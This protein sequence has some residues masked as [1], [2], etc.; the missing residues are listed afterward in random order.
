[1]TIRHFR[2]FLMVVKY[3]SI[4][5]AAQHLYLSQPAVSL[6]IKE[7]ESYYGIQLFDRLSR[8][9][10]ITDEGRIIY[11]TALQIIKNLDDL[12]EEIKSGQFAS[13]LRLGVSMTIGTCYLPEILRLY[14]RDN[15]QTDIRCSIYNSSILAQMILD[16]QIDLAII[17]GPMISE[18]MTI[19][20]IR[21]D[22]LVLIMSKKHCLAQNEKITLADLKDQE[23]LLRDHD[24]GT[25]MIIDSIFLANGLI[26]E[27]LIESASTLALIEAVRCNLGISIIPRQFMSVISRDDII[28][29]AIFDLPL[30]RSLSLIH[31]RNKHFNASAE[32]FIQ[33]AENTIRKK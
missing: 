23:F 6:A 24:S 2:I 28:E 14:K 8:R 7:M 33:L 5:K 9:L 19:I 4:T 29:R 12:E 32:R 30:V 13:Q 1:M 26:V 17:E 21:Q 16:H 27:P 15:P 10:Y 3:Q 31:L 25:R 18:R 22:D 20:P 11:D